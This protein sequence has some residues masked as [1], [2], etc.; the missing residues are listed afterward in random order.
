MSE[1]IPALQAFAQEVRN[2]GFYHL[3]LLAEQEGFRRVFLNPSDI[4]GCYSVLS[5]FGLVPA[6][7]TGIDIT[8]LLEQANNMQAKCSP[9]VPIHDNPSAWLEACIG[10]LAQLGRDKLT[11]VTSSAISSFG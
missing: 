3:V 11:L 5:Y 10:T 2:V 8:A 6:A 1:Q 4:G 7:L 9:F